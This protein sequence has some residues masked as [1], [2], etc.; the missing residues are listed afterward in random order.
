MVSVSCILGE[1]DLPVQ[2]KWEFNDQLLESG[3]SIMINSLGHRVSY[4]MIESVEGRHAGNYTCLAKNRA[5]QEQLTSHL[6]VIG[7]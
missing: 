6:E 4:L 1:G 7:T 2:I 5:G 3:E